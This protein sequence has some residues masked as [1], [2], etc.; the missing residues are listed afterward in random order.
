MDTANMIVIVKS[1][2]LHCSLHNRHR[3]GP[4]STSPHRLLL[5]AVAVAVGVDVTD[6]TETEGDEG[7]G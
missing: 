5:T 1:G 2:S 7:A 3:H 6:S 4:R